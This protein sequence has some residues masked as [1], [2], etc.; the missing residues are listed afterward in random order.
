MAFLTPSQPLK[1][2]LCLQYLRHWL[3]HAGLSATT[4]VAPRGTTAAA[5]SVTESIHISMCVFNPGIAYLPFASISFL[6]SYRPNPATVPSAIA[7]SVSYISPLHTLTKFAFFINASHVMVTTIRRASVKRIFTAFGFNLYQLC[8]E[9]D[10]GS[11]KE[12][13]SMAFVIKNVIY[14]R[15]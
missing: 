8:I 2:L 7:M 11:L 3:S 14:N 5:N 13:K 6:P 15:A 10:D 4:V 1:S 12:V 9:L